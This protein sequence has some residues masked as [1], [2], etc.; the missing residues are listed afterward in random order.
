MM[1][2][3][4]ALLLFVVS[5]AVS[6]HS[7][8]YN[9]MDPSGNITQ[10][11]EYGN[12]GSFNPNK[13]DTTHQNKVVP[14]GVRYW[15][16]DRRFGDVIP[17]K[18]DT[19]HHLYQNSVYATGLYGQYNTLGSNFTARQNR[20]FI[21]RR[22]LGEFFFSQPYDFTAVEPDEFLFVNTL[23]PYAH[24]SYETSGN[25]Q[26]GEDHIDAKYSVNAGKRLGLGF[27]LDYHYVTGDFANQNISNFRASLF[28]SYIGDKYQMHFLTNFY[29]RKHSENGGITN[30][31]YITHPEA[32]ETTFS[33]EEIPTV[34]SSNWNRNYA[35]QIFLTHRYN[36]GFYRK[37]KMT[38]EEIKARQFA[39]KSKKQKKEREEGGQEDKRGRKGEAKDGSETSGRPSGRPKDAII[40]GDE[41][42]QGKPQVADSTRIKIESQEKLDSIKR[43]QAIQDSID[44]TMKKEYVPVTSIIHTLE[45]NN[46]E[47]TYIG[48]AAPSGYY[49]D[50]FYDLNLAEEDRTYSGDSIFDNMKYTSIKN[51][52]ALALLEGFNK[53]MKAGLKAFVSYEHRNYKMP[54]YNEDSTGC[55]TQK[56]TGHC[57]H[58]GGQISRTQGRAFHFNLAAELGVTGLD[59][60]SLAVDFNTDLNFR[61]FGDTLTLAAK[62]YF[63]RIA[64]GSFKEKLHSKHLWWDASL[65]KETR[66]HIEGVFSYQKTDTHLRLAVTQLKN[67]T[68]FGMSYDVDSEHNRK[69]LTGSIYQESGGIN[70]L[71]A[72]LMQNLRWGVLNWENV[73]TVQN[74]S[75]QDVLPLPK[76]NLFSNLYLKFKIARVLS[77]ELG[78]SVTYFTKYYAPDYLPQ[79]SQFAV[80][81]NEASRIELGGYP[82]VDVYANFHLKRAR[83]FFAMTHVNA[84]SGTKMN[85]LTPHY[86]TNGRTFHFGV[87]WNFFN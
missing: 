59:A 14:I 65:D 46:K 17:S 33:E 15:K 49:R 24:V 18:P 5:S 47:R 1:K 70:V 45:L 31:E 34:L 42:V 83:F 4:L 54:G 7:Q 77:T 28:S 25:R 55:I 40:M 72:Q 50:T 74:S 43:E 58:V 84:G 60:G 36:I 20:I 10:R 11:D 56:Y 3:S 29:H 37:V 16:V 57:L 38:E 9:Q 53:Y 13:R 78:A 79:I 64:H 32:Q 81:K 30:D 66:T 71:T 44:A 19:L 12:N 21:D 39:Q 48:Y 68:Y 27:D 85:F 80:Q 52:L 35:Q 61:L 73:L 75:N 51:T 2:K 22:E 63:H 69:N 26:H 23:S 62:A 86:P 76:M 41:P 67:Y 82:W 8:V 87:S 6:I